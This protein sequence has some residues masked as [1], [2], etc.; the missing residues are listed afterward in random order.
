MAKNR[1]Q[2]DSGDQDRQRVLDK[3]R[4]PV[5]LDEQ[6]SEKAKKGDKG[7]ARQS[8]SRPNQTSLFPA[9]MSVV[10]HKMLPIHQ[11]TDLTKLAGRVVLLR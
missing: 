6:T 11:T 9:L 1:K 2:R 10:K 7:E 3:A 8:C 4:I 5:D